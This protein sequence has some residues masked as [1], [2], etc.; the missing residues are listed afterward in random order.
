MVNVQRALDDAQRLYLEQQ[1]RRPCPACGAHHNGEHYS[2]PVR[3]TTSDG[4]PLM[5]PLCSRPLDDHD[6]A[7]ITQTV[8]AAQRG[9][10]AARAHAA[11]LLRLN[12]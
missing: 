9:D 5:C 4:R 12:L 8:K 1:A 3:T 6:A 11:R 10:D 7:C 2:A